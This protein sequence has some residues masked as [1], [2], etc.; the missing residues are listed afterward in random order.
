LELLEKILAQHE[1]APTAPIRITTASAYW[2]E[3]YHHQKFTKS[4][5]RKNFTKTLPKVYQKFTGG[6]KPTK[7]F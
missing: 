7:N 4:L 2:P 5:Q 3:F 1:M 6:K